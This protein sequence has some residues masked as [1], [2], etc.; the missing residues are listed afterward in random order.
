METRI[1]LSL[2]LPEDTIFG[3]CTLYV[4]QWEE[5][6]MVRSATPLKLPVILRPLDAEKSVIPD[7]IAA[8]REAGDHMIALLLEHLERGEEIRMHTVEYTKET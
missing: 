6:V 2:H 1:S 7:A 5:T 3:T 8:L 4:S